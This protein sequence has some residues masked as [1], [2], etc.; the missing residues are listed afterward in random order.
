MKRNIIITASVVVISII[1]IGASA[2]YKFS[3]QIDH[4]ANELDLSMAA[5]I[6]T[7]EVSGTISSDD[8][9]STDS[10]LASVPE[11]VYTNGSESMI[12]TADTVNISGMIFNYT[13]E[14]GYVK[15]DVDN[16][17]FS[18]RRFI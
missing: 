8:S 11:G 17:T 18:V 1:L 16:L 9:D 3:T 15:L 4:P 13:L 10:T 5:S 14:D 2:Y 12:F 7:N 6:V